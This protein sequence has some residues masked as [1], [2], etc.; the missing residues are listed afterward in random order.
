MTFYLTEAAKLKLSPRM[1]EE[2]T[3]NRG[4]AIKLRIPLAG[5]PQPKVM[6]VK[7][8]EAIENGGRFEITSSD[9]YAT[10]SVHDSEK[11]DTGKYTV[12]AENQ[13]GADSASFD[14]VISGK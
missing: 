2:I 14:I 4:Q 7:D 11:V 6:W 13:L 9:K 1:H 5:Q 12:T 10:L 3:F 8:G